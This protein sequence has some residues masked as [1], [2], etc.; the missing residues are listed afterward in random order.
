M[1]SE[2]FTMACRASALP[3]GKLVGDLV[4]CLLDLL[5]CDVHMKRVKWDGQSSASVLLRAVALVLPD[6]LCAQN[7]C[8]WCSD[9][10]AS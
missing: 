2:Q 5:V 4:R 6:K 1:A 3:D 9:V 10:S 7:G 8:V